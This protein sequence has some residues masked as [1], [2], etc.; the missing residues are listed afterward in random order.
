MAALTK[1]RNTANRDGSLVA[2]PVKAGAKLYAGALAVL[3]GGL[4]APARTATGLVAVGRCDRYVD[5]TGG[6]DGA[7]YGNVRRKGAF[8]YD[9][10]PADLV[11]RT[12]IGSSCYVVD[13]QTVAATAGGAPATRSVAGRVIDVDDSG[14]WVA[15]A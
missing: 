7:V 9:N 1:D 15:F 5:N 6:A 13:D 8:L 11:D 2:H 14:V 4:L 10:L 12:M 3:D